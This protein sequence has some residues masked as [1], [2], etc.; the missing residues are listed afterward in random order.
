MRLV[1]LYLKTIGVFISQ[2]A[3]KKCGAQFIE[4]D[5]IGLSISL[6]NA[7][8]ILRANNIIHV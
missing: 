1:F 7:R 5:K 4:V 8:V 2:R 6:L 3:V